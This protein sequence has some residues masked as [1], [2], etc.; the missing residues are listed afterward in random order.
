MTTYNYGDKVIFNG[1][2]HNCEATV[3]V[4]ATAYDDFAATVFFGSLEDYEQKFE[5]GDSLSIMFSTAYAYP[6][7]LE[8][9]GGNK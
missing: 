1:K 3:I 7:E 9:S 4:G 5:A 8:K 2:F 6:H